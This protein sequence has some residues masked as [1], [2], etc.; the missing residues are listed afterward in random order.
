MLAAAFTHSKSLGRLAPA[1]SCALHSSAT[2]TAPSSAAASAAFGLQQVLG[3]SAQ[4]ASAL[5]E[6]VPDV[7]FTKPSVL[8]ERMQ[9]MQCGLGISPVRLR[10]MVLAKPAMLGDLPLRELRSLAGLSE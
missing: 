10:N 2:L 1:L 5:V 9:F 8:L 4:E 3:L 6:A 7:A